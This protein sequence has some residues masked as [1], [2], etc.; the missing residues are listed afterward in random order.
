MYDIVK[1]I[2]KEEEYTSYRLK[3]KE[4]FH[5]ADAIEELGFESLGQYFTEKQLYYLLKEGFDFYEHEPITGVKKCID[6]LQ[7][8]RPFV[9]FANSDST[10]VF[11]GDANELNTQYCA[12]H[13][14]VVVPIHTAGGTI[15]NTPG[16]FSFCLCSKDSLINEAKFILKQVAKILQKYTEKEVTVKGNDILI[17]EKKVCGSA[18]YLQNNYFMFVGYFSFS[19]KTDLISNICTTTK[20]SKNVGYI[21]FIN[22][23]T[24]RQ[25]VAKWLKVQ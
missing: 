23:E 16:D 14:I 7:L 19:D 22:R 6:L 15:V 18:T 10:F 8:Q 1:A 2:E 24:F 12:D 25:E 3:N 9:L 4:P 11:Q 17:D 21:D 13:D 20:I 5:L